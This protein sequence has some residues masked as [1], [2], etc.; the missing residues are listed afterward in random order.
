M[1]A[2]LEITLYTRK[3]IDFSE[4]SKLLHKNNI[5]CDIVEIEV[6][7]D[8]EYRNQQCL[9]PDTDLALLHEYIEQGKICLV[10]CMVNQSIHG[11]CYV[12]KNNDIYELSAWF[13]VDRYPALDVDDVSAKN[14]WFYERLTGEIGSLVETKDFVI[15]GI[16]VETIITYT[17]NV[18]RMIENS[19]NV[20]RW[21]LPVSFDEP[22]IGYRA[23]KTSNLIV[24]DKAE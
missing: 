22:I 16:G 2:V 17:V 14:R 21:L 3:G 23:E 24:L 20:N 13:D 4:C 19:H 6:I 8:W 1:G 7:E 12:Q 11:G 18:K 10:R 5:T 15:G 9:P